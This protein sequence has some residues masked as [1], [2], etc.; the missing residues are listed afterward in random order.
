MLA[1]VSK[2]ASQPES[3]A[4]LWLDLD[5]FKLAPLNTQAR[6]L[7]NLTVQDLQRVAARLFKDDSPA[8]IVV[9]DTEQLKA[10]FVGSVEMRSEKPDLKT[11]AD[12]AMPAKKP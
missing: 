11:A 8:T 1:D 12:P 6:S 10:S 9:G 4:S 3:L 5:T 2:Q 7:Q